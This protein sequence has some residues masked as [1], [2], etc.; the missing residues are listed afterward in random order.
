VDC[1]TVEG[2]DGTITTCTVRVVNQFAGGGRPPEVLP[3][4]PVTPGLAVTGIE[5]EGLLA[6]AVALLASGAAVLALERR[7]RGASW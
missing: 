6:L 3:R 5:V 7:R 1:V 2:E 4:G